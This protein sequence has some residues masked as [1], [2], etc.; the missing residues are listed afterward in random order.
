M[1]RIVAFCLWRCCR[2]GDGGGDRLVHV[3]KGLAGIYVANEVC[4]ILDLCAQHETADGAVLLTSGEVDESYR[5]MRVFKGCSMQV[6]PS[7][8]RWVRSLIERSAMSVCVCRVVWNIGRSLGL[9][10]PRSS[11]F[12]TDLP[13]R[14][15]LCA[16]HLLLCEAVHDRTKCIS[17]LSLVGWR[18]EAT[19]GRSISCLHRVQMRY[20]CRSD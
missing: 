11:R 16:F 17:Y 2:D 13:R 8:A 7:G 20:G 9:D 15:H 12:V 6:N 4:R 14:L 10:R 5:E 18:L 1:I 19:C 3:K